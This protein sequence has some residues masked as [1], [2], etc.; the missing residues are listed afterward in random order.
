M[1]FL[2]DLKNICRGCLWLKNNHITDLKQ[3]QQQQQQQQ[4]KQK[5]K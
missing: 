1:N 3:Q 2:Q 4:H 5:Q